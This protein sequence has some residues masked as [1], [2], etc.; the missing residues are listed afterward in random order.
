MKKLALPEVDKYLLWN[1]LIL[2]GVGL[3]VLSS[4]SSVLSYQRFGNNYY[5]FFRQLLFGAIPGLILMY[6]FSRIDYHFWQKI[7]PLLVLTGIGMLVAVLIP[8]IGFQVGGARRWINL[9]AFLF[10]PAEFI[11][12]AIVLYLASWYDKRQ[13]DVHDLYYGFLPIL[14]I[15]VVVAGLIVLE[16]DMGT[17]LVLAAIATI[18]FFIGGARLQYIAATGI[19]GL[20]MLWI[21]IKAAPYRAQRFLAFMDPSADAKGIS[22]QIHQALLAIGSG[23]WW[24]RG[25]GQSLQKHSYLPEPIGDSIFAIMSEEMGFIRVCCI[26]LLFFF[27]AYRGFKI[28]R[29][30]PDTFGKLVAGGITAWLVMQALINIGGISGITPLTGIPLTFISY[31]STALAISL[32]AVGIMLS[33]SRY[34]ALQTNK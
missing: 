32:A 18:M 7:A 34:S 11:K 9:G 26:L 17:M 21:L 29:T 3:L 20:M 33:I 8:G 5:Y 14:A 19:A 13:H 23:G 30:A 28:A 25:F 6:I 24:G 4:A 2:L 22:Y 15:V 1:V 10:Q 27:L 16:P 31:G 12:L